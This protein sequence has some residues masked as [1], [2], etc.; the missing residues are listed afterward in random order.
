MKTGMKRFIT[1]I[2]LSA[3]SLIAAGQR[4]P[5]FFLDAFEPKD[6]AFPSYTEI[7]KPTANPTVTI[8]VNFTDKVTKIS[9]YLFGNNAN[10][11]ITKMVNQPVLLENIKKLN[12]HVLRFPGGNLSSLYFWNA[13]KDQPPADA[14]TQ[15]PNDAGVLQSPGYWYGQNDEDW[16]MSVDNYY[17]MLDLTN[18]TGII[19]VNYGYA[20]YSTAADPVASAAHLAAEWV[21]Y[22]K[23][24]TRFWEIGNESNGTWQAGYR[25]ETSGNKDGQPEI[26][27]G[28]L[29]GKHFKVF[30][31]SM[32]KAAKEVG[33]SI[34]IGA[35]L[36]QE[37]PA[38]WWNSTDKTWNTGVFSETSNAPDFYIIH[39]YYT[40][41]EQNSSPAEILESATKV[42]K[43][44]MDF[45]VKS[46]QD[47]GVTQKP[48]ALTEWNIFAAGSKQQASYINGM[49]AALVLGELIKNGYGFASRWD[50]ANSWDN[51][52]DHGLFSRGDEPGSVPLWNPRAAYYYMY[53]FQRYTGDH[54][55]SSTQTG[56]ADVV[57]Y[58]TSFNSGDAGIVV[59]NRGTSAQTVKIDL[60]NFGYGQ[61]F[62]MYTL[63]GGTDNGQFSL[64]VNINGQAATYAS[65][66]PANFESIKAEAAAIGSGIKFNSP[67]SSVQYILVEH[68]NQVVTDIEGPHTSRVRIFPN[69]VRDRINIELP[70]AEF[71]AVE[72]MDLQGKILATH[73]VTDGSMQMEIKLNLAPGVYMV[74]VIGRNK[75]RTDVQKII[76]E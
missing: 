25:I 47:A 55:V 4:N 18:S 13:Q 36:L 40:P 24:R 69:Y 6:A 72:I 17:K 8:G 45:V 58:A 20:R 33:A 53:Y 49:H 29:Y 12:P 68:G 64:K 73:R 37:A 3:Y 70:S 76:V 22:D 23:G 71:T 35:Q 34:Y 48:V 5:G 42:T 74:R 62:Y 27:T 21:R 44:M 46:Q 50:L 39:S 60:E 30:A 54:L 32:R 14:P 51:G 28:A 9:K 63:T 15:L 11:Y 67:P 38:N 1:L 16:T 75:N 10:V 59:V 52:N 19:T 65:G 7:Q 41:Y 61:R 43:S 2:F 31:D 66:G 26:I 57:A 56:S